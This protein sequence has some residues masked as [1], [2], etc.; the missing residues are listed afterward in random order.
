MSVK[1]LEVAIEAALEAGKYLKNNID[2]I[3]QVEYKGGAITNL[4]TEFDK[5]SEAIII[6]KLKKY[7]PDYNFLAEE[8]GSAEV[9]SEYRWIIDPLDGTVNYAHGLPIY[10]ISI[11]LEHRNEIVLG[12]IYNPSLDELYF[13]EKGK[14][15]YL[16]NKPIKVSQTG[17]L[18][19]SLVV[20]G[21]PYTI[22][23]NPEPEATNFRNFLVAAQAV[24]RLGSAALDLAYVACGRFDG[25]WEGILN[26]WDM[27]A[28]V[29]LVTEAGGR[30]TDY[31]GNPTTIYNKQLLATNGLIHNE[32]IEVLKK[33]MNKHM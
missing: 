25:F 11:A 12:V 31:N 33:G 2:K 18:I 19:E 16:N 24:R 23:K 26:A 28:G 29:L 13:S 5:G 9:E 3:K 14:G 32:M 21:F 4:V 8:S 22:N 1:P 10:S 30:W 7:F 20:T 15:S 17:K 6:N 27:A